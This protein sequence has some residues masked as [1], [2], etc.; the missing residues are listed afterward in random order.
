MSIARLNYFTQH[1]ILIIYET[2]ESIGVGNC[3]HDLRSKM[4]GRF[5]RKIKK[6]VGVGINVLSTVSAYGFNNFKSI[7][8]A[9][10]RPGSCYGIVLRWWRPPRGW[11]C[12]VAAARVVTAAGVARGLALC[13]R[14]WS[15]EG[16]W[17]PGGDLLCPC[18]E[19]PCR[20][21][22]GGAGGGRR[23]GNL[24]DSD[25]WAPYA[26][27]RLNRDRGRKLRPRGALRHDASR[28]GLLPPP[29]TRASCA[30]AGVGDSGA[31]KRKKICI[32]S[33]SEVRIHPPW[34]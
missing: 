12:A 8:I 21:G 28:C 20:R 13:W 15:G 26:C 34:I 25:V 23:G 1:K 11:H 30:G 5:D 2:L 14:G 16:G 6:V 18:G 32:N 19:R 3:R 31:T 33:F 7:A 17:P 9:R 10:E 24:R 22:G 4:R 27:G 29:Q